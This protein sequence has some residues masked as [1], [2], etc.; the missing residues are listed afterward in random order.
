LVSHPLR[1]F[2]DIFPVHLSFIM[3]TFGSELLRASYNEQ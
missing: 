3:P 2:P 1:F